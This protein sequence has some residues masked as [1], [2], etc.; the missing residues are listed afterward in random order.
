MFE[1]RTER[2]KGP[3]IYVEGKGEDSGE[4]INDRYA[5]LGVSLMCLG[6]GKRG[7]A[8]E[9]SYWRGRL[10]RNKAK[11]VVMWPGPLEPCSPVEGLYI[12]L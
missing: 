9:G 10:T 2:S 11:E 5:G 6:R 4:T 8:T 12:L 1:Q 3:C 7:H